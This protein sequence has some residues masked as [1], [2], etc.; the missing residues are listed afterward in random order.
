MAVP[1]KRIS[2]AQ[3]LSAVDDAY[4]GAIE[5]AADRGQ[6]GL[7]ALRALLVARPMDA[8]H[9][10]RIVNRARETVLRKRQQAAANARHK[11]RQEAKAY[12]LD[13]FNKTS[14]RYATKAEFVKAMVKDVRKQ[15]TIK[16]TESQMSREWIPR[17]EDRHAKVRRPEVVTAYVAG[18]YIGK[19][20]KLVLKR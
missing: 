10:L 19:R 7:K 4:L 18:N 14:H 12:V 11:P 16:V 9:L 6:S 17:W 15:F 1:T 2:T 13:K 8:E 3:E 5:Q 20:A